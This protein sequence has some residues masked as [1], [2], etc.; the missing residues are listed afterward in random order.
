MAPRPPRPPPEAVSPP[1]PGPPLALSYPTIDD[2]IDAMVTRFHLGTIQEIMAMGEFDFLKVK[3]LFGS[4]SSSPLDL[5]LMH[6]HQIRQHHIYRCSG[7]HIQPQSPP[8]SSRRLLARFSTIMSGA[9]SAVSGIREHIHVT[10]WHAGNEQILTLGRIHRFGKGWGSSL[11]QRTPVVVP[12]SESICPC[13]SVL[14][15]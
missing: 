12:T 3:S 10:M 1:P 15:N 5:S 13:S 2:A 4:W 9:L 6:Q 14:S 11:P 7:F 8:A